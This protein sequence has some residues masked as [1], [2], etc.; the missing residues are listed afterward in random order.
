MIAALLLVLG[1]SDGL[2]RHV[3]HP[4]R[5]TMKQDCI[6]VTGKIVDATQGKRRDGLRHEGDG[7]CHGWLE[8]DA[9]YRS[10]LNA[11]NR[12][13]EGGHLVFEVVCIYKVTQA[14]AKS[15]CVGYVNT[16]LVPRPGTHVRMKGSFVQDSR[17]GKWNEIHPV[18]SIEVIP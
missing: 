18:S 11:G 15:S 16:I 8:L 4:D 9:P 7:D 13:E 3:Y 12:K 10:M 6:T 2:W 14:D 17:H 1:C 5:L